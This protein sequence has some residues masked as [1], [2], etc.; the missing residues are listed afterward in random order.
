MFTP[1]VAATTSPAPAPIV[2]RERGRERESQ[3]E[4]GRDRERDRK[5]MRERE[6]SKEWWFNSSS[7]TQHCPLL[8][9]THVYTS[10]STE[11]CTLT[12]TAVSVRV[13]VFL[14][15]SMKALSIALTA[16]WTRRLWTPVCDF[17]LNK[18]EL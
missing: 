14:H 12:C 18:T 2:F 11:R 9:N 4:R 3:R 17:K 1:V 15:Y 10:V 6:S 5:R 7:L 16:A 13:S 8:T